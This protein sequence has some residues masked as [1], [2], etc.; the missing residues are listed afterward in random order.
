MQEGYSPCQIWTTDA[1][2]V[3]SSITDAV[4]AIKTLKLYQNFIKTLF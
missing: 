4:H 1:R 3:H 2:F